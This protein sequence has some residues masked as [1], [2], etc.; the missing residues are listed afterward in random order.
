MASREINPTTFGPNSQFKGVSMLKLKSKLLLTL[1]LSLSISAIA[2]A[3]NSEIKTRALE[4]YGSD[5]AQLSDS[6]LARTLN[7]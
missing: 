6:E 3:G 1:S 4:T 5:F 2:L 7:N